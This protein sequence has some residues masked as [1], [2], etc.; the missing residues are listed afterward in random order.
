M[1]AEADGSVAQPHHGLACADPYTPGRAAPAHI[2][3]SARRAWVDESSKVKQ[4]G[5]RKEDA[6]LVPWVGL[7][8]Q[9]TW[10]T[11]NHKRCGLAVEVH[12]NASKLRNGN[13][14]TNFAYFCF[15]HKLRD[16]GMKHFVFEADGANSSEVYH[17]SWPCVK[18]T[19]VPTDS[20]CPPTLFLFSL[21][22]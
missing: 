21:A 1:G 22:T 15:Q 16:T 12:E 5:G 9:A 18:H 6:C 4:G 7:A 10:L 14:H 17:G 20:W 19:C 8:E 13:P 3:W 11:S 2:F